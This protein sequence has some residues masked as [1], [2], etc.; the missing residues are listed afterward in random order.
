MKKAVMMALVF[1]VV[2][3]MPVTAQLGQTQIKRIKNNNCLVDIL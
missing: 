1:L 3:S 2:L